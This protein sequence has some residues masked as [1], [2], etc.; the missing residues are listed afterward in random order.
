VLGLIP[1]LGICQ[2]PLFTAPI[3]LQTYTF[4]RSIGQDP[5]KVLDTI[6]AMGITEVESGS[7]RLT[8]QE[9]KKLCDE[10]GIGIPST[11]AG[12]EELINK[13]DSVVYK[14][15]ALGAK[16]VMCA[17][18]PHKSGAFNLDNAKKRWKISIARERRSRR[19]A[20]RCVII[21]TAMNSSLMKME[22][23]WII[24]LRTRT[25]HMFPLKWI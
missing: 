21:R 9:F 25:R 22:P 5:A 19:M 2:K 3:G 12:Y 18:I 16:Y 23:C 4:R 6:R 20:L 14:T 1:E 15:K 13:I 17:W 24:S 10:R 8:P 7:G 11:G